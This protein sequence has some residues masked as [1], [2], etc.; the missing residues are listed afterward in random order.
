MTGTLVNGRLDTAYPSIH[1]IEPRYYPSYWAFKNYHGIEDADGKIIGWKNHHELSQIFAR[2]AIRRTFEQ[3]YGPE[4]KVVLTEV[5]KMN[6]RQ[7]ELYDEFGS[8]AMLELDQFYIDGTLPG[9]AFIRARQ[10]M[11]HPNEF[12]NLVEKGKFIDIMPGETPAKEDLLEV[13]LED[14]RRTKKPL[15]IF[16]A[17]LPQHRRINAL[18]EKIGLRAA[19]I[20]STVS[21]SKRAAADVAFR[22]G[23]LDAAICSPACTAVGFNWQLSGGKEVDHMIFISLDFMDATFLQAYRRAMRGVRKTP[24]R[25]T[26]ME[27]ED[28]LDQRIFEI[29]REKSVEAN[30]VDPTRPKVDLS[31]GSLQQEENAKLFARFAGSARWSGRVQFPDK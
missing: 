11:E 5:V 17:L 31:R 20:N 13:H 9:V 24:L 22:N 23:T 15:V 10:I 4:S 18:C 21:D 30:K 6:E 19:M 16:S 25:I 29:V 12:P 27:Y 2:H 26:V 14:H 3:V 1:V 28:S 8:T 7:R